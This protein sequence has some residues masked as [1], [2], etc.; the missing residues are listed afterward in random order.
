LPE[1]VREKTYELIRDFTLVS[2]DLLSLIMS[3][4]IYKVLRSTTEGSFNFLG[5]WIIIGCFILPMIYYTVKIRKLT[6]NIKK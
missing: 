5:M 1:K 3:Y 2:Y 6:S 4:L